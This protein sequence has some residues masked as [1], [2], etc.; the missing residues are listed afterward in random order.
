[1]FRPLAFPQVS[2]IVAS[3]CLSYNTMSA[4]AR[5]YWCGSYD[6]DYYYYYYYYYFMSAI[7]EAQ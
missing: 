5:Y 7:L 4:K 3:E 2:S 1:V 6:Y